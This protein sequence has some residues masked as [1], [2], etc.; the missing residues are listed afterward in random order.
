MKAYLLAGGKSSRMGSDKGLMILAGKP[1]IAYAIEALKAAADEIHIVTGVNDY[2]KFGFEVVSDLVVGC[3][4]LGGIYSALV[5]A[6]EEEVLICACDMPLIA[7][8]QVQYLISQ[9]QQKDVIAIYEGRVQP[10]FGIYRRVHIA[11][12]ERC[13]QA[14]QLKMMDFVLEIQA[15]TLAFENKFAINP[16]L[17][18]NSLEEFNQL[19]M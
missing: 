1:M 12:L 18:V 13:L 6:D 3:G 10:L 2:Q 16:F 7:H 17:N 14:Q 15:S 9:Y 8:E 4:P 11:V 19:K 5:H